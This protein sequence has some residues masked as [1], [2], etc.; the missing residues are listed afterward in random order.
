MTAISL[1]SYYPL[2]GTQTGKT[3]GNRTGNHLNSDPTQSLI[4]ALAAV[5]GASSSNND[6]SAYFLN[7]SPAAQ[8]L[9]NHNN[10]S[11]TGSS[12]NGNFTLSSA[13]RTQIND[14]LKKYKDAPFTQETFD[15]I[16]NDLQAAKLGPDQ[17]I[18]QDE[19]SSFN[20]TSSLINALNGNFAPLN[21]PA[22][23]AASEHTKTTNYMQGIITAWQQISGTASPVSS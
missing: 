15:Q 12:N 2:S 9:L 5:N 18:A 21:T 13:Q 10:T 8:L 22:T 17:L 16:Q 23:T 20:P 7:L 4:S 3:G 1:S 19:I 14:I 6:N 11:S